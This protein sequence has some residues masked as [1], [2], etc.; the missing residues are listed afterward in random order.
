MLIKLW[1][2]LQYGPN[3]AFW[4]IKNWS[5][6]SPWSPHLRCSFCDASQPLLLSP[7]ITHCLL[8]QRKGRKGDLKRKKFRKGNTY[9]PILNWETVI[10]ASK[11][12]VKPLFTN[13]SSD[14][15]LWVGHTLPSPT[16]WNLPQ[17]YGQRRLMHIQV[18]QLNGRQWIKKNTLIH[19]SVLLVYVD[20]AFSTCPAYSEC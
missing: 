7:A 15:K 19:P 18:E 5:E 1:V 17:L 6:P 9:V 16:L 2:H 3:N 11:K 12:R 4:G 10:K 13:S 8:I 14:S 20:R